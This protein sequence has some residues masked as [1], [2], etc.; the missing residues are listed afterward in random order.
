MEIKHFGS[1]NEIVLPPTF[2]GSIAAAGKKPMQHGEING[3]LNVKVVA[4]SF[5]QRSN[6][7][8]NPAFFPEPPKDQVRPDPQ[9]RDGLSL[10]SGMRI[11]KGKLFAMAHSRAYQRLEPSAGLEF[12][13][14]AQSPEDLLPPHGRADS[15]F[16]WCAAHGLELTSVRPFHVAAWIEDIP[17]SKPTVKQKL[18]AVRMLFDFWLFDEWSLPTRH[19]PFAD[20]K[21]VV[22]KGKTPVFSR[23]DAKTLLDSISKDSVS[24]LRD[25]RSLK[26]HEMPVHHLLEQILDEY[27]MGSSIVAGL[28][29]CGELT[30]TRS[31]VR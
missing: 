25:R 8:L 3:P 11:D 1:R 20:Q 31:A 16:D 19:T 17:G 28:Y 24:G 2:S 7:L 29:V 14:P 10:S 6:Y 4:A 27:K 26:E 12:I 5:E 9:H 22:K 23:E 13:E 30:R 15:F 21:Y 18:A